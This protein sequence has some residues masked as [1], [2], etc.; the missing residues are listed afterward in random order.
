MI[1]KLVNGKI[2]YTPPIYNF[3]SGGNW[4]DGFSRVSSTGG[5]GQEYEYSKTNIEMID[6]CRYEFELENGVAKIIKKK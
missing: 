3:L 4:K 5:D 2:V 6:G 1:G